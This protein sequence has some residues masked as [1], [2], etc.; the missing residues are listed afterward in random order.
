MP[1]V[2]SLRESLSS[3]PTPKGNKTPNR[4]VSMSRLDVL[5]QPRIKY[6]EKRPESHYF[7]KSNVDITKSMTH[8]VSGRKPVRYSAAF[9]LR[10]SP[11]QVINP[12]VQQTFTRN[13]SSTSAVHSAPNHLSTGMLLSFFFFISG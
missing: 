6:T 12:K 8:L 7:L 10:L 5:A 9:E 13:K 11:T 4:A 3:N 1:V 2:P